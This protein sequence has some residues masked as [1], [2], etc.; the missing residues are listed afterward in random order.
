HD[1]ARYDAP[2]GRSATPVTNAARSRTLRLRVDLPLRSAPAPIRIR[3]PSESAPARA[4]RTGSSASAADHTL[5]FNKF[6]MTAPRSSRLANQR[7]GRMRAEMGKRP[8]SQRRYALAAAHTLGGC[9]LLL[10]G[11]CSNLAPLALGEGTQPAQAPADTRSELQKA[12]KYWGEAYA[13]DPKDPQIA[14]N[15]ARDLSALGEKRQAFSVLQQAWQLHPEHR[16]ITSEYGRLA[17]ALDRVSLAKKLLDQADDP[18]NS[19]WRVV[20]ARG[21]VLAKQGK[22]G[23]AIPYYEKALELAP[24]Q[25]SVLNNLALAE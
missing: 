9:A 5:I 16:A 7:R 15:Y 13:K 17:L 19:D 14:L 25:A 6:L 3:E 10:C 8:F 22:Y 18:A 2:R 20:S 11:A 24:N 1:N 23:E 12:T 21:T 4:R